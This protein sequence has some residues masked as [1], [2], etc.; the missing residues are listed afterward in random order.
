MTLGL[1]FLC[2]LPPYV[3]AFYTWKMSLKY[4]Q[5]NSYC[6]VFIFIDTKNLQYSGDSE[7]EVGRYFRSHDIFQRE[8]LWIFFIHDCETESALVWSPMCCLEGCERKSFSDLKEQQ[9]IQTKNSIAAVI[10]FRKE[11]SVTV[12]KFV[13]R[14]SPY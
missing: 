3:V 13:K 10:H 6:Y 5:I 8:S 4:C 11:S 14:K 9:N 12:K 2:C 1:F 7:S